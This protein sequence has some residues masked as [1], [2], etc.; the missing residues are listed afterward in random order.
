MWLYQTLRFLITLFYR[1]FFPYEVIGV[2]KFPISGGAVVSPNHISNLD[3]PLL[4]ISLPRQVHFMAKEEMFRVPIIKKALYIVGTFP[5]K[6][7]GGDSQA[8]KASIRI[9]R[10]GKVLGIFPQGTRDKS[11]EIRKVHV[12]AAMFALRTNSPLVPVAVIGPYRLF[13]KVRIVYGEPILPAE[14]LVEGKST[15]DGVDRLSARWK[16]EVESLLHQYR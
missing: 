9:L 4:G 6:R 8:L 13:R 12:G 16:K 1:I 2:E 15:S 14:Y 5:V 3:P 10:E 7:G 11:G